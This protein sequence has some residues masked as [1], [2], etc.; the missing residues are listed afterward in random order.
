MHL[1]RLSWIVVGFNIILPPFCRPDKAVTVCLDADA[2]DFETFARHVLKGNAL[3]F[4][5]R[6]LYRER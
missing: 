1:I 5:E 4:I 2:P 6:Q 3:P